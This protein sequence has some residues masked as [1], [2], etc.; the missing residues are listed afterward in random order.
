M[1]N[2]QI[3]VDLYSADF[4]AMEVGLLLPYQ[5]FLPWSVADTAQHVS[6]ASQN[7]NTMSM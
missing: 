1:K 6:F 5:S 2:Q 7:I 4:Q 3:I